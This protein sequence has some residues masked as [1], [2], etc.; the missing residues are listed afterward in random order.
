MFREF[1]AS[2]TEKAF[3]FIELSLTP[4]M[5]YTSN[6]LIFLPDEIVMSE[7]R[8]AGHGVMES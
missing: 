8:T 6:L 4:D 5:S 7:I 2:V 3:T 1:K